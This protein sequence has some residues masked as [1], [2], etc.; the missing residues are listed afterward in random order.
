MLHI[1]DLTVTQSGFRN[2]RQI[3]DMIKLVAEGEA[4]NIGSLAAYDG[5][6]LRL[7]NIVQF[8]DGRCYIHDGHHRVA[9]IY[10][11]GRK[12][13]FGNEYKI[14]KWTYADYLA[15]NLEMGWVTP[16]DPRFEVR[17]DD[18]AYFKDQVKHVAMISSEEAV[19]YIRECQCAEVYSQTRT[20]LTIRDLIAT[21][22]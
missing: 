21:S 11:G 6:D 1:D 14:T 5:N 19:K 20:S 22:F 10:L 9:A 16:F 18:Y 13:L 2:K 4:F 8:E 12:Y 3:K 7:I 17:V 15:I